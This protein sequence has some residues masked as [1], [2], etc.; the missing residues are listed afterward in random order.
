MLT[1]LHGGKEIP[2]TEEDEAQ[3]L[4]SQKYA[5]TA[6]EAKQLKRIEAINVAT[7]LYKSV[8]PIEG[9]PAA[10]LTILRADWSRMKSEVQLLTSV[11]DIRDYKFT[12]TPVP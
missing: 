6:S 1:R 5:S 11:D 8:D 4:A 7:S 2:M 12:F 10:Y 3:L 9:D